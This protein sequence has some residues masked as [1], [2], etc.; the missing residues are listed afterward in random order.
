M[1][2]NKNFGIVFHQ[3]RY[4]DH[5]FP[6]FLALTIVFVSV[7]IVAIAV[8]VA[9]DI[10]VAAATAADNEYSPIAQFPPLHFSFC[11]LHFALFYSITT[12]CVLWLNSYHL[13]RIK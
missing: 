8:A 4:L 2:L 6:I 3:V 13:L 12:P 11:I 5:T 7:A 10:D 1:I 9:A